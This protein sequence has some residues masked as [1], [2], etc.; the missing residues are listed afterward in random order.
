MSWFEEQLRYR[1]KRDD[2]NFA[3]AIG[4]IAGAVMGQRLTDAL[5]QHEIVNSAM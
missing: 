5:D 1:K 3:D 2:E 4:S